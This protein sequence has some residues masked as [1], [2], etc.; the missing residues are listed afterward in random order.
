VTSPRAATTNPVTKAQLLKKPIAALRA[1]A[2]LQSTLP[3]I[4]AS[5]T[6]RM[7]EPGDGG[8]GAGEGR[9]CEK[10]PRNFSYIIR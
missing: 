7:D 4:N 5:Q 9:K 8:N 10:S 1:T 3:L 2:A 6:R